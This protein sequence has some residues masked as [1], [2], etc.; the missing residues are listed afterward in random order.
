MTF[1]ANAPG[2]WI[3]TLR[4]S[5]TRNGETRDAATALSIAGI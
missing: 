1:V 4:L 3:A 5:L 2:T